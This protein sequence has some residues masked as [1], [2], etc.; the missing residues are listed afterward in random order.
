M[1]NSDV[2]IDKLDN[3]KSSRLEIANYVHETFEIVFSTCG[4]ESAHRIRSEKTISIKA[5][6]FFLLHVRAIFVEDFGHEGEIDY[7]IWVGFFLVADILKFQ[8]TV[9][10]AKF[11]NYLQL[12]N[13]LHCNSRQSFLI[14]SFVILWVF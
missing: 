1:K 5:S 10:V 13:W 2:I 6:N 12:R 9:C 3:R 7:R 8:V 4:F 11:M 14:N